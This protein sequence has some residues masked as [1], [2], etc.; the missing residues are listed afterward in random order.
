MKISNKRNG[1][2]RIVARRI[3]NLGVLKCKNK[4]LNNIQYEGKVIY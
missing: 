2:M 4:Y 1:Y 3:A